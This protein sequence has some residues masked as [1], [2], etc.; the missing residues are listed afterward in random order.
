MGTNKKWNNYT[1][2]ELINMLRE[3]ID[4][5]IYL[6]AK[7]F[8]MLGLPTIDTYRKILNLQSVKME[9]LLTSLGY[10]Y[11]KER[12]YTYKDVVKM[13]CN[14]GFEL[15]NDTY[16]TSKDIAT[17]KCKECGDI[18]KVKFQAIIDGTRCMKCTQNPR[19]LTFTQIKNYVEMEYNSGCKLNETEE[20]YLKKCKEQPKMSLCKLSFICKCGNKFDASFNSFKSGN[21][22]CCKNGL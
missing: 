2:E 11:K 13:A 9:E 4:K 5:N 15:L 19:R 12:G 18:K 16:K 1:N 17:L 14:S 22:R 6:K 10:E 3:E 8:S 21:K 20:S 7:D